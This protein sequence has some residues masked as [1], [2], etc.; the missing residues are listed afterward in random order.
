MRTSCKKDYE[1]FMFEADI[2]TD[3]MLEEVIEE[4]TVPSERKKTKTSNVKTKT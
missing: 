2:K 1:A 3:R 4:K